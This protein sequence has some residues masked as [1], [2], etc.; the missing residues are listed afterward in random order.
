M[1]NDEL[2]AYYKYLLNIGTEDIDVGADDDNDE[3]RYAIARGL[4]LSS[5]E[6]DVL[7][8]REWLKQDDE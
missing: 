2:N 6:P 8:P 5:N 7:H 3:T 4:Y 1:T